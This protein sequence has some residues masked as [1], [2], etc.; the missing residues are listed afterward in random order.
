[1]KAAVMD[2][3]ARSLLN[4]L[5]AMFA[6]V[7]DDITQP[8]PNSASWSESRRSPSTRETTVSNEMTPIFLRL[9]DTRARAPA[10]GILSRSVEPSMETSASLDQAA[11]MSSGT[12]CTK[13]NFFRTQSF[14]KGSLCTG[15][16]PA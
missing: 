11:A 4:R 1:M 12:A 16:P 9:F 8:V 14:R 6:V 2:P 13:R 5:G 15:H 10:Y 3:S 7:N